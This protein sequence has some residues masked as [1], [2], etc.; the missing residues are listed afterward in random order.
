[1]SLQQDLEQITEIQLPQLPN[2][3]LQKVE[4]GYKSILDME[5][6][7]FSLGVDNVAPDFTLP[8]AEGKSRGLSEL[9][10]NGNVVLTFYRGIWCPYCQVQLHAYQEILPMIKQYGAQLV[11][12]S[13]QVPDT[14]YETQQQ[15]KLGFE[16]LSDVGNVV[17]GQYGICYDIP[18]EHFELLKM[19]GFSVEKNYDDER[20]LLPLAATYIIDKERRIRWCFVDRDY[21]KRAEPESILSALQSL[22][23]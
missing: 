17:S 4:A 8:N 9:L 20:G 12:V 22:Q 1:M 2:P 23:N 11:A 3:I 18:R 10:N 7:Q 13:P 6:E 14:S 15:W 5:L 21:R 19:I 16:V